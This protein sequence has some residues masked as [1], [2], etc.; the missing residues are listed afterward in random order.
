[1]YNGF[2]LLLIPIRFRW[3][4]MASGGVRLGSVR[5]RFDSSLAPVQIQLAVVRFQLGFNQCPVMIW[6]R[7]RQSSMRF[8]Q[9]SEGVR[10]SQGSVRVQ[11]EAQSGYSQG[12]ISVQ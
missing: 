9:G 5:V 1:M 12:S 11:C 2:D 6:S 4:Q 8:N 10:F 3:Y 7:F